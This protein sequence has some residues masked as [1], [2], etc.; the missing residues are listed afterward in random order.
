MP[1]KYIN[2][3]ASLNEVQAR[4]D[5]AEAKVDETDHDSDDGEVGERTFAKSDE[6][7]ANALSYPLVIPYCNY[8]CEKEEYKVINF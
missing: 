6:S 7:W 1:I 3:H 4:I 8:S 5:Q 2:A